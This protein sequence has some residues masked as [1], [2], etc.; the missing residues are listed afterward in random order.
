LATSKNN[1]IKIQVTTDL[2]LELDFSKKHLFVYSNV[3]KTKVLK[4][5][6]K[7]EI[8]EKELPSNK[9]VRPT[10]QETQFEKFIQLFTLLD[11]MAT[12]E[13]GVSFQQIKQA[14]TSKGIAKEIDEINNLVNEAISKDLIEGTDK[15][16][17]YKVKGS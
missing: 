3:W 4:E 7:A 8:I 14:V 13:G 2:E 5:N 17:Y 6:G 10:K 1:I 12:F 15:Y 16:G 9:K 11:E